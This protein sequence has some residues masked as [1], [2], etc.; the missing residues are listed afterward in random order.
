MPLYG[1]GGGGIC[2]RSTFLLAY[3]LLFLDIVSMV[4]LFCS[5]FAAR[6]RALAHT[7]QTI[8]PLA[9]TL[10]PPCA[11]PWRAALPWD[12]PRQGSRGRLNVWEPTPWG[13]GARV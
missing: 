3:C 2:P 4:F 13:E 11:L 7:A 8:Q 5:E 6:R 1:W 9:A 12:P 10:E